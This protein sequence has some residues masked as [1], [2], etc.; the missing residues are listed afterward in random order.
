MVNDMKAQKSVMSFFALFAALACHEINASEKLGE[1]TSSNCSDIT[2]NSEMLQIIDLRLSESKLVSLSQDVCKS[3]QEAL[4]LN[5]AN[6]L[7][8]TGRKRGKNVIC[9]S[10]TKSKPCKYILA[11]MTQTDNPANL[12]AEVFK[13]KSNGRAVLNETVERLYL[14]PSSL[15]R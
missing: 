9:L 7:V 8:T 15:I 5:A 11:T 12:L 10:D 3:Y 1:N 6:L 4:N 13:L 14:T 2:D